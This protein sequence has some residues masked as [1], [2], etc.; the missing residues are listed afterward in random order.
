METQKVSFPQ[1]V[2]V[3]CGIDVHQAVIVATIRNND[4]SY[5]TRSFE[6]YT[7]SLKELRDWCREK[8]VTHVAMESTG[9]YWKPVYNILE[10][11]F[12]VILVNARHVKNIPGHK[13]DK[14]DSAWLSKLLLG[15][16]LKGSFIPPVEIR[17]LRDLV[18]YKRKQVQ[19]I[20]SESNR[21]YRVLEDANIK[22]S[23]VMKADS[24]SGKQVIKALIAGERD[25]VAL[26]KL[27]HGKTKAAKAEIIK[28]LE[29]NLREHHR[30]M[31][32]TIQRSIEKKEQ[33]VEEIEKQ[34]DLMAER[35]KVEIDLLTTIDGVGRDSA[36]AI[37]S[38]IGTDMSRFPNEHHLSSLG[39]MSPGNNESAGKK[40]VPKPSKEINT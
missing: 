37:I 1:I 15:G 7:S 32:Q 9:V 6:A 18:R 17:D 13:T 25:P 28:A 24:V 39:G 34:I 31:L 12:E 2:E 40:K 14:K 36:I 21:L 35:Y 20:S 5:E 8:G 3:G 16:L 26:S 33:L 22:L 10:E 29:G 23:T 30:F 38:E 19:Q 27:V 11:F 4:Q